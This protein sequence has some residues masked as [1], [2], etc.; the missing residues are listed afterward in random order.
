VPGSKSTKYK[1]ER[2]LVGLA[3]HQ[4]LCLFKAEADVEDEI[5]IANRI[6]RAVPRLTIHT[7]LQ[8]AHLYLLKKWICDFVAKDK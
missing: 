2:D 4:R 3:N 5:G 8:D 6:L 7:N 1:K